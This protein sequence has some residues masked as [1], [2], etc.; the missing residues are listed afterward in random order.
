MP[1]RDDKD[2]SRRRR[3]CARPA[4]AGQERERQ[5]RIAARVLYAVNVLGLLLVIMV[6]LRLNG[7]F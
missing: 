6:L 4:D 2:R 7:L 5:E 3:R 1:P